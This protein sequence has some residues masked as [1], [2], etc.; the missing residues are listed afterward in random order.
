MGIAL[1]KANSF[2]LHSLPSLPTDFGAMEMV[3]KGAGVSF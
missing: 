3:K 2:L 1:N